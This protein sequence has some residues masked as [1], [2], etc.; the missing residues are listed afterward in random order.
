MA[1]PIKILIT[2]III[3][4]GGMAGL[5]IYF[6]PQVRPAI[7]LPVA[8]VTKLLV[9]A[10]VNAN[11]NAPLRSSSS[12]GQANIANVVPE[13]ITP[14]VQGPFTILG[15]F[16]IDV[17][18]KDLKT[19]R[20]L[21]FDDQSNLLVSAMGEGKV[22]A[23]K[24]DGSKIVLASNLNNPHGLALN[25]G[26]LY[27]AETNRV[28]RYTYDSANLKLGTKEFLFNLP[29]DGEHT[30]R[31]LQFGPN[32]FLYVSVGS[33]CNV[34]HES[35]E[36]R[37]AILKYDPANWSYEIFAH[38]L[39]NTVFFILNSRTKQFWGNDMGR[40]YLGDNL[41]PDDL[42][43]LSAG[44]NYGWPICYGDK[45]H[46]T[47]FD[48]NVYVRDPCQDTVAPIFEYNAHNAP[49][50]LAFIDS[51]MFPSDWQGDLLV[52][53]HGSWNSSVPVG[54]KVVKLK[55]DGNK[56]ISS[57]DFITGFLT[58]KGAIGRPVDLVFGQDGALY[59]SDDKAGVVYKIY[60]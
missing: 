22:Y 52:S 28:S 4:A 2:V 1:R 32:G 35:D 39:R 56:V 59:L 21:L 13:V 18:A 19:P 16:Q 20:V 34:C 26:Y 54:Y 24:S 42:N 11:N 57:E 38:G 47:N 37:A 58:D 41:P 49:L 6:Y 53:L 3:I 5:V 46:D 51:K 45:V 14:T 7:G 8:D 9:N 40:D 44:K 10:N 12:G 31:T 55:I 17:F 33:S 43:I 50:G 29:N 23:I 30:T 25:N 15:N 27:V 60:K 36:R 48:K